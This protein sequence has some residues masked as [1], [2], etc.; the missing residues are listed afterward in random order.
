MLKQPLR[1]ALRALVPVVWRL[2]EHRVPARPLKWLPDEWCHAGLAQIACA[3]SRRLPTRLISKTETSCGTTNNGWLKVPAT[4]SLKLTAF[5]FHTR[6]SYRHSGQVLTNL[7]G[8]VS[9][10]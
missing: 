5:V 3:F 4:V 10:R 7:E 9:C 2:A 8:T 1:D 6:V